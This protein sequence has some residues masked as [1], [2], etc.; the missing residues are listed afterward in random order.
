MYVDLCSFATKLQAIKLFY[1]INY[2]MWW[3]IHRIKFGWEITPKRSFKVIIV[4]N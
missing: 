2:A 3:S 1:I 4:L